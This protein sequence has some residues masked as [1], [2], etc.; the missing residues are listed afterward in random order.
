MASSLCL[1]LDGSDPPSLL[2]KYVLLFSVGCLTP[3]TAASAPSARSL[4]C[5]LLHT[6]VSL[7]PPFEKVT[8]LWHKPAWVNF[9][10][11]WLYQHPYHKFHIHSPGTPHLCSSISRSAVTVQDKSCPSLTSVGG[12]LCLF[13]TVQRELQGRHIKLFKFTLKL[14]IRTGS[15]AK[16]P[17][18]LLHG[19]RRK[20]AST[21]SCFHRNS[22]QSTFSTNQFFFYM[23]GYMD[24]NPK[25]TFWLSSWQVL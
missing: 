17:T 10:F 2:V 8:L 14:L 9:L 3:L 11:N 22:P 5:S 21:N 23:V 7:W 19:E 20:Y 1:L 16:H 18:S 6:R 25:P 24:R 12:C 15:M 4:Y 13:P